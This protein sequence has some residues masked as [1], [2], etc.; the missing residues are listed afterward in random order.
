VLQSIERLTFAFG[1]GHDLG[2]VGSSPVSDAAFSGESAGD[3]PSAPSPTL[4]LSQINNFLKKRMPDIALEN[5]RSYY[6]TSTAILL[7]G[8]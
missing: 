1:S 4:S 6:F 3:S 5:I 2:V 7:D 8:Q